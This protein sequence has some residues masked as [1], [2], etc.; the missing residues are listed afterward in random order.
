MDS[1]NGFII[2][3]NLLNIIFFLFLGILV[4]SVLI[5][6]KKFRNAIYLQFTI[7]SGLVALLFS[8]G[9]NSF[10][11]VV[12]AL[13]IMAVLFLVLIVP[14]GLIINGFIIV[15]KEGFS[16]QNLLAVLFAIFILCGEAACFYIISGVNQSSYTKWIILALVLF[17]AMVIYVSMV[18]LAFMFYSFF[19]MIIPRRIHFNYVV[20]LG[21]GLLHGD[22]VTKLLSQRID[23]GIKVF[24]RSKGACKLIMSGGQ[25][26][27]EKISEAQAMKNYAVS[28]G[29]ANE[30]ILLEEQS[31]NTMENLTNSQKIIFAREGKHS[32]AV[33]TSQY[34]ML[35][36]IVYA[37]A[38][39]F[40]ITG[41]GAHT[42]L[43]YWPAAMT[44]EYAGLVKHYKKTYLFF[45][46]AMEILLTWVVLFS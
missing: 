2:R 29:I 11:Y 39:H 6:R 17:A 8:L 4:I 35:R 30:D 7:M 36:T 3:S 16:L 41:I 25:G 42:A 15:K 22:T 9:G 12:Q 19:V 20:V 38:L 13:L 40:Q 18:F 46:I 44:R 1:Y 31:V 27:D 23:K 28:K 32:V 45:F 43:Y 33:V 37:E 14:V 24:K 26:P 5:D 10:Y 34:H 21:A